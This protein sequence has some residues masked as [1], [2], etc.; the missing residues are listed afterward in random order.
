VGDVQ[1]PEKV[2]DI[3]MRTVHAGTVDK[4]FAVGRVVHVIRTFPTWDNPEER[5]YEIDFSVIATV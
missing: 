4:G 1:G 3:F 5:N 2:D